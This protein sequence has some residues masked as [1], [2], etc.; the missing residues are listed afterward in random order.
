M[1]GLIFV[2]LVLVIVSTIQI[3][4]YIKMS[5]ATRALNR[6][7]VFTT[8][9]IKPHVVVAFWFSVVYLIVFLGFVVQYVWEWLT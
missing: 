3:I 9:T 6:A 8:Y 5:R 2:M 7:T 4:N 1:I